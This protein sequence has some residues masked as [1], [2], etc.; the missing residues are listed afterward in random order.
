MDG[1]VLLAT[2]TKNL[3]NGFTFTTGNKSVELI[4]KGKTVLFAFEEAIG[5]MCGTAVLD[6]DGV[7]AAC[8][9]ASLTCYLLETDN[10]SLSDKLNEIY[11]TY[12]YH[13]TETSYFI[14]H[15]PAIIQAIFE[16]IRNFDGNNTVSR[17]N[18]NKF[19]ICF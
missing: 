19:S 13:Y 2:T 10:M 15:E 8:Q 17:T 18:T 12:G 4:A 6:K 5:F 9:L 11:T 1:Y 16:H 14:C 7:S 3:D